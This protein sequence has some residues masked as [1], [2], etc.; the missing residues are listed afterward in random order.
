MVHRPIG[1]HTLHHG[2]L[3]ADVRRHRIDHQKMGEDNGGPEG[4]PSAANDIALPRMNRPATH[5]IRPSAPLYPIF[6]LAP[7]H[8]ERATQ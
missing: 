8:P 1:R 2:I 3:A 4:I 5:S 6:A 7:E